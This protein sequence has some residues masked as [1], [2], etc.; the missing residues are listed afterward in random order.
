MINFTVGPV[1]S[2]KKILEVAGKSSPY[3]RTKEFSDIMFQNEDIMLDFLHA[4]E[5][6]RCIF[7]TSSGTGAMESCVMNVLNSDDKVIV[8]NGGT[9]GQRFVELCKLH[10]L[11]YTEIKCEF[12]EQLQEEQLYQLNGKGYTALLVNMH[13]TSSGVLYDMNLLSKFCKRNHICFIVDAISAF[14]AD[15]IDMEKLGV[16]VV[17]T[18]SQKAL[19]VQPGISIIALSEKAIRRVKNNTEKCLYLS[20]KEAIKNMERG[21]T[22]FTP[23]VTILL[24]INARLIAIS[25]NGGI[26][27]E[28]KKISDLASYFRKQ[29]NEFPFELVVKEEKDR[30]NAVTGI[31]TINHNATIIFEELKN[32]YGIWICPNGGIYKD[33]IFRV[34]HIGNL[35]RQ[36]YDELLNAFNDLNRRNLI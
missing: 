24:Q 35:T 36:N 10:K 25:Q 11:K 30:S 14:I 20:L 16:D 13:E 15:E 33:S 23:A 26:E 3:F 19:A 29:I 7:L 1:E 4:S 9:F 6:S 5:K 21:Q 2:C 34:G 17:I 32:N 8:I 27:A 18:G 12:G 22:P 31:R 28:R